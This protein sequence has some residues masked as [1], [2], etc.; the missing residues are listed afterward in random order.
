MSYFIFATH[1]SHKAEELKAMLPQLEIKTL[2]DLNHQDEIPE[3]AFDLRGNALIKAQEIHDLFGGAVIAD[4]TGLE[5]NALDGAPGV[6][7]ARYAGEPKN[8]RKNLEKLL[9]AVRLLPSALASAALFLTELATD[10]PTHSHRGGGAH[11]ES[12]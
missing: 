7:S 9:V 12:H 6:R 10:C 3:T 4:D 2:I 1:N 5:V 11:S 8:D